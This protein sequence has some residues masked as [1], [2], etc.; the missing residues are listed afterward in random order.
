MKKTI[1]LAVVAAVALST[2]SA[3]ATNGVNLMGIGAKSRAMGGTGVAQYQGA[4][5]GFNNPA[6]LGYSKGHEVSIAGTYFAPDVSLEQS[7]SLNFGPGGAPQKGTDTSAAGASMLPAISLA[8]KATD[9]FAWGLALY[10][11][12]GMG[13]DY[14]NAATGTPD[15]QTLAG[16][17]NDNWLV[18]RFAVPLAYTTHGFSI[19][20]APIIQYGL[21]SVP[22]MGSQTGGAHSTGGVASNLG[23]GFELG[24]AYTISGVTIGADY[25]SAISQ[26]YKNVFNSNI[27]SN[28][29]G[30]PVNNNVQDKLATPASMGLG[31]SWNIFDTGNTVAFDYK[32]IQYGSADGLKDFGWDDQNVFALGYEYKA[33][34]WA[35]RAGYNYGKQPINTDVA[36]NGSNQELVM[37]SLIQFP[38]VTE[39]H[40]TIGGSYNFSKMTSLDL[41]YVYA[42]GSADADIAFP[43][44]MGGMQT[45]N[46]KATNNQSSLTAAVNFNF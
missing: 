32:L 7:D 46:I 21:L 34:I 13:V 37:G 14:T 38:G 15:N 42:T 29:S 20:V 19:G 31:V 44:G 35:V 5:S 22:S 28:P 39:S 36:S 23:Y 2:T 8:V 6:L 43:N 25:K 16:G 12:A 18:M 33:D 26:Q 4:E 11:V 24:A 40:Y 17:S 1:K 9:N 27:Q 30:S 45:S 3:F 10:G 41:A